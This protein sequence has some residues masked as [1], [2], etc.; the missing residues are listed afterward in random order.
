MTGDKIKFSVVVPFYNE[1]D[2]VK[3]LHK[4]LISAL[5]GHE[6]ELVYVND[7]STDSTYSRLIKETEDLKPPH[8]KIINFTKNLG[9]SFAFKAG[10][11]NTSFDTIVFIDG[12][13]QN[14]PRDIP[15]LLEKFL[16]GYDL[17]QGIRA[18][19]KDPFFSKIVPSKIANLILRILCGSKFKDLGCSLKVFSKKITDRL[20]FYKGFH[21]LLPVYFSLKGAKVTEVKVNHRSRKS[22]KSK[23]GFSRTI[24]VLF[25]VI[26]INFFEKGSNNFI[27]ITIGVGMTLVIL[28]FLVGFN[29]IKY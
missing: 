29:F 8:A 21:R 9:Q 1:E 6:Y 17:A 22:G 24:E 5:K 25:E 7:G 20:F 10:L 16:E 4:E 14:D 2:N 13:L 28:S 11:D 23:Y 15:L 27:Y 18:R 26:K 3:I 12:D 19:R